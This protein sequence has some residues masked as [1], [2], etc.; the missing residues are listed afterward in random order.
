MLKKIK[1]ISLFVSLFILMSFDV[2]AEDYAEE[3]SNGTTLETEDISNDSDSTTEAVVQEGVQREG[4]EENSESVENSEEDSGQEEITVLDMDDLDE[5]ILLV[6]KKSNSEYKITLLG[7]AVPENTEKVKIPIWSK[8]NEQDDIVWYEAQKQRDGSYVVNFNLSAHKGTGLYAIHA[9]AVMKNGQHIFLDG[10]TFP[11]DTPIIGNMEITDYNIDK[12]TFRVMLTGINHEEMIKK[13]EVP[14]W[15][16]TGGQDDIIWYTAKRNTEGEYYVDID[17]KNHKYSMGVYNIHTYITDVTNFRSFKGAI[18]YEINPVRGELTITKSSEKEYVIELNGIKIPGG[19]KQIQFPTWSAVNGQDD[20]RWY[21]ASRGDGDIY[22]YKMSIENHKGL[23]QFSVHAY[24]K[25]PNDSMVFIGATSFKTEEPSLGKIEATITDKANGQFQIKIS[26]IENAGLIRQIQVP[27]WVESGQGDI[28]WYTATREKSGNYTVNTSIARHK[29]NCGKY[30]IH[31]YLTDIS[32]AR[33]FVSA[34][35]CNMLPEFQS[36]EVKD[37]NGEEAIYRITISGL[38][39]PSGE[40]EIMFPV[41]GEEGGQNDIRWYTA[42]RESKGTYICDVKIANHKELGKY[43]VHGYCKTREN[44]LAFLGA[45]EFEVTKKPM[46]A[47]I[48]ASNIDG[49]KGTFRVTATGIAAVSGVEKV[50]IPVWC[51]DDQSDI[52]WY[53][54]VKTGEG[55]YTVNVDVSKHAYHFG[56]YRSHVYV[57][58]R[59]GIRT[60]VG[61]TA[62]KIEAVNY[63]YSTSLSAT[64]QEIGIIGVTAQR[65]QFPTWSD[66]N[67]QDDT[68][69]YEGTNKGNG[70]W[71]AIVDSKEHKHSGKFVTHV[72]A[73]GKYV[74]SISY[75]LKKN[76]IEVANVIRNAGMPVGKTLYVWGGGWNAADTAAGETA[77]HIGI[78]PEWESYFNQNRQGYSYQAG[79]TA[80]ERGE[81]HWRFKGLD[82]SGYL[83]WIIYNSVQ[84]GRNAS[85]YVVSASNL[86]ASLTQY[87]Y[88]TATPC[89]PNSV[90]RPGD[91]VSISGHCFLCLG[92]CSDGSVLI[93]HSTP[94]GGVQVSGTVN[95]N[96]SSQASRLA[97]S[98]MQ[99]HYPQWWA[100]F[101]SE[102]KQRVSASRYL[103]GTKF[104]WSM[105]NLVGDSENIRMKSANEVINYLSGNN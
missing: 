13:V 53:D 24:A 40:K 51:L 102:G 2:Y 19:A 101:G 17:I 67:G 69:W 90:F 63:V 56:N 50:Q 88:G 59:N 29:Y 62:T 31:V 15:S 22:H 11:I 99:Q 9:Y 49:T 32:G 74:N 39:V 41:W 61:G 82:C 26:D 35:T 104:S 94:N 72:Y 96:G 33:R 54:A 3:N 91:I 80:W 18:R 65:V 60:F 84:E 45:T 25:M 81:R 6:E 78:W 48:K 66:E 16:E 43:N 46:M 38:V 103:N 4:L 87:G 52:V 21:N 79:K 5:D 23:G 68:I 34:I 73:D 8:I 71:S 89:S 28:V 27:I 7:K 83:G 97:Q 12:G 20:I 75:Q 57:T 70:K 95:G 30:N 10:I 47:Q 44:R 14:I 42:K 64:R 93:L 105:N 86:A 58:S 55:I 36:F 1:K 77:T 37:I 100:S 76:N 92:Q 98:F 85:G